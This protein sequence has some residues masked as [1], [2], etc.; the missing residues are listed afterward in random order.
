[1]TRT[2]WQL[3]NMLQTRGPVPA[4]VVAVFGEAPAF[5]A[6]L[7]SF[8]DDAGGSFTFRPPLEALS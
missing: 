4:A 2:T 7:P 6:G 5:A 1:M 8:A 3:E